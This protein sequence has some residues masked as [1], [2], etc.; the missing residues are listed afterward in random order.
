MKTILC[1]G[2]SNTYG[3]IPLDF[4]R[5][6]LEFIPSRYRFSSDKRW[7]NILGRGL[8]AG[9]EIIVEG[10]KGRTTVFDNPV[11]RPHL[12][13]L[14]YLLPCLE[15]HA[16]IDLVI[17][18]LGTNDLQAKYAMPVYEIAQGIGVLVN[19]I[20][21]SACGPN[22]KSPKVLVLCPP[23]LGKLTHF[24]AIYAASSIEQSWTLAEHYKKIAELYQC[25]FFDAG[26]IIQSSDRDGLHF[27]EESS[28]ILGKALVKVVEDI[29]QCVSLV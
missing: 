16:P 20:Q 4:D 29:F 5:R 12:N 1:Y 25:N 26:S 22:G 18:M 15:S 6:S 7:T 28:I 10:L 27:E 14:T 3:T 11:A 17:L 9:Y 19:T 21:L 8:G 2:D 13:G 23:P 24:Q